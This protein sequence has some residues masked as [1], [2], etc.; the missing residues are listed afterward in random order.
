MQI[1]LNPADVNSII[2]N[3][4]K[5]NGVDTDTQPVSLSFRNKRKAGGVMVDVTIG[6][7]PVVEAPVAVAAPVA[8]APTGSLFGQ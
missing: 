2:T 5:A 1:K 6:T 4:L 8:E 3:Y 7:A